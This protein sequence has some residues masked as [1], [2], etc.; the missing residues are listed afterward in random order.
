M[1]RKP[2]HIRAAIPNRIVSFQANQQPLQNIRGA[3]KSV[4]EIVASSQWKDHVIKL[5]QHSI[6]SNHSAI[7]ARLHRGSHQIGTRR[8][9]DA[10]VT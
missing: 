5:P 6:Y 7:G 10:R 2:L 4:K 9:T 3:G 8:A 1:K